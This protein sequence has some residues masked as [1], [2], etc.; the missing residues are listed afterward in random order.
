MNWLV[1][2]AFV[3]NKDFNSNKGQIKSLKYPVYY[4]TFKILNLGES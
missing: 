4:S 2:N 1:T 3:P